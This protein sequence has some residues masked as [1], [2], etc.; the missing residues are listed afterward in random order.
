[1]IAKFIDDKVKDFIVSNAIAALS[2]YI[3]PK[4]V[5]YS[6]PLIKDLT[7][8]QPD[9]YLKS[10]G[11]PSG[12]ALVNNLMLLTIVLVISIIHLVI[13]FVRKKQCRGNWIILKVYKFFT[14]TLYLRIAIEVYLF[15][16]LM[17]LSEIKYYI[18]NGGSE[19]FGHHEAGESKQVKGNYVST[20]F[21]CLMLI[22]PISFLALAYISWRRNKHKKSIEK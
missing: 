1:M 8:D 22:L 7:F 21:S 5:G 11:W 2:I 17:L 19:D 12:S 6:L 10:L 9:E 16:V 13:Y 15:T 20:T 4:R 3:L 14:L 18:K